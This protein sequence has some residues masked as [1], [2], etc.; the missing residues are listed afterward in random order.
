MEDISVMPE[1]IRIK[2]MNQSIA[3]F[4][5]WGQTFPCL[6]IGIGQYSDP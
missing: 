5:I 3:G 2:A 6:V 4:P 1:S